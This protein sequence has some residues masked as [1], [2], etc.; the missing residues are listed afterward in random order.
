MTTK[1]EYYTADQCHGGGSECSHR[2]RTAEAAIRCLPNLPSGPGSA[3]CFSLATIHRYVD[4]D[5]V[6]IIYTDE[7]D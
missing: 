1:R 4:G 5:E 3:N 7:D 6:D 2:H